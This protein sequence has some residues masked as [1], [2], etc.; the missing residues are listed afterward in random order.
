MYPR[1]QT[2]SWLDCQAKWQEYER[3]KKEWREQHPNA[4]YQEHEAAVRRIADELGI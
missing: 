3:R 4:S 2:G 1:A